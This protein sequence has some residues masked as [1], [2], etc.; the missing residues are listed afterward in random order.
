MVLTDITST[1]FFSDGHYEYIG[2]KRKD[3]TEET[4][5][6]GEKDKVNKF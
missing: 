3:S 1:F 2:D 6:I 5:Q 4:M